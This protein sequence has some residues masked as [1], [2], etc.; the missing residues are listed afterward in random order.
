MGLLA[1][2]DAERNL[3]TVLADEL[4]AERVAHYATAQRVGVLATALRDMSPSLLRAACLPRYA[5]T[6]EAALSA[7]PEEG[8]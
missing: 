5:E 6:V 3:G 1:E 4:A 2:R 8:P 7:A